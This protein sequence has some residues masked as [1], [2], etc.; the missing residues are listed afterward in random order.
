MTKD[1][2]NPFFVKYHFKTN[3]GVRSLDADRAAE[4]DGQDAPT[5]Q[6]DQLHAIERGVNPSRTLHV[7]VMPAA[8]AAEYRFN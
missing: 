7:Q 6:T 8:E 1:Y 4:H 2:N 5:H 3:Q